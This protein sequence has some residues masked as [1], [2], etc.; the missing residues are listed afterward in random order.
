MCNDKMSAAS[1]TKIFRASMSPEQP[2]LFSYVSSFLS[3][4]RPLEFYFCPQG[5][6]G[7]AD[8]TRCIR[9]LFYKYYLRVIYLSN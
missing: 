2:V 1:D 9:G 5:L 3:F 8:G 7:K 4:V 6:L